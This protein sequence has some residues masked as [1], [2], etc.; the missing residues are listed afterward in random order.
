MKTDTCYSRNVDCQCY[1]QMGSQSHLAVRDRHDSAPRFRCVQRNHLVSARPGDELSHYADALLEA[2]WYLGYAVVVK[3][4]ENGR[5][6]NVT[7]HI[8]CGSE[9]QVIATLSVSPVSTVINTYGVERN[10]LTIRQKSRRMGRKVD[11]FSKKRDY[12]EHQLTLAFAYYHFA[13]PHRGLCQQL[14]EPL[15]TK[16]PRASCKKWK[17]VTP[18]MAVGLTDHGLEHG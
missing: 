16:G 7:M 3:D 14:P 9:Q 4:R 5:V 1:G 10:H 15:P 13:Q 2:V 12:L 17:P 18:A 8:V 11:A 6:V